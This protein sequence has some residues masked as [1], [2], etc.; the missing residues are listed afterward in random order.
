VLYLS[1]QNL[2]SSS[3]LS[4]NVKIRIYETI[5]LPVVQYLCEVWSLAL[6]KKHGLSV[7]ENRAL[8]RTFGP[9][10]HEVTADWRGPHEELHNVYSS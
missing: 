5:I 4:E 1:V 10:R 7:F 2:L 6:R 3:L 9:R 8:R